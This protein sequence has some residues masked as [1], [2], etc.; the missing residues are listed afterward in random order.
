ME[1]VG[2]ISTV[3]LSMVIIYVLWFLLANNGVVKFDVERNKDVSDLSIKLIRRDSRPSK[4]RVIFLLS[5]MLI[6]ILALAFLVASAT[7][8]F[9]L[10]FGVIAFIGLFV[11]IF[12]A[13]STGEPAN[14]N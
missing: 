5:L 12:F 8:N 6:I 10:T 3:L 14:K 11:I 2:I 9:G 13:V 7:N 4:A 1:T